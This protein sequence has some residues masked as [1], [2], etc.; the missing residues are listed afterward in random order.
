MV[1]VISERFEC[2]EVVLEKMKVVMD[3]SGIYTRK[4][5]QYEKNNNQINYQYIR[6]VCL[7]T[8]DEL[9]F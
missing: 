8:P 5:H 3:L 7:C 1:V 9:E 6:A 4:Y 2:L